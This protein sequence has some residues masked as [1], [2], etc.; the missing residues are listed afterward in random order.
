MEIEPITP[1]FTLTRLCCFEKKIDSPER[2]R[3]HNYRVFQSN[4]DDTDYVTKPLKNS[5][6]KKNI[7][8]ITI[9]YK[10]NENQ[11]TNVYY[12]TLI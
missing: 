12:K 7:Q 4:T 10:I 11:T 9:P 1:A 5:L 2:N 3:I 6:Y 8:K